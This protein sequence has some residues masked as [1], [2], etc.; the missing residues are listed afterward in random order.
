LR[1]QTQIGDEPEDSVTPHRAAEADEE[2]GGKI[3]MDVA[4]A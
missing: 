4:T 2:G 1:A 3:A